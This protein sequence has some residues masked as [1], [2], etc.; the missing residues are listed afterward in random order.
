MTEQKRAP[1]TFTGPDCPPVGFKPVTSSHRYC[2]VVNTVSAVSATPEIRI[3]SVHFPQ[4]DISCHCPR[5][6]SKTE[7]VATTKRSGDLP[8]IRFWIENSKDC[9][10]PEFK[11]EAENFCWRPDGTKVKL[12]I[13][14]KAPNQADMEKTLEG[15]LKTDGEGTLDDCRWHMSFEPGE[16]PEFVF[17]CPVIVD[18]EPVDVPI[19]LVKPEQ[20]PSEPELKLKLGIDHDKCKPKIEV[21]G[22]IPIPKVPTYIFETGEACI[23]DLG[24]AGTAKVEVEPK[25]IE[26]ED[27]TK[28]TEFNIKCDASTIVPPYCVPELEFDEIVVKMGSKEYKSKPKLEPRSETERRTV[29]DHLSEGGTK[30]I[31]VDKCIFKVSYPEPIE[32]P[33]P[34]VTASG[35]ARISQGGASVGSL[36]LSAEPGDDCS[37]SIKLSGGASIPPFPTLPDIEDLINNK[38]RIE[39]T[40]ETQGGG[41]S[42]EPC[43]DVAAS[44]TIYYINGKEFF[45]TNTPEVRRQPKTVSTDYWDSDTM[46]MMRSTA[47][48]DCNGTLGNTAIPGSG[49]GEQITQLWCL[50]L[51]GDT[52]ELITGLKESEGGLSAGIGF[53]LQKTTF[54]LGINDQGKLALI[55]QDEPSKRTKWDIDTITCDEG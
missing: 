55:A 16:P 32:L 5:Y 39:I 1:F 50:E 29:A 44:T 26:G 19:K 6:D 14:M 15:E 33:C 41:P 45:R 25:P 12:P 42:S 27:D 2:D 54:Q 52:V 11:F 13:K 24:M 22:S 48:Y 8:Y 7:K 38:I 17:D 23:I 3:P 10:D 21:D 53:E 40:S 4:I 35:T 46:C 36:S 31:D 47:T 43:V 18:E 28:K 37:V 49:Q 20:M 30:T 51:A 34:K 9:C